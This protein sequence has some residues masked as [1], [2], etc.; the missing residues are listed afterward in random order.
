MGG[1]AN[2]DPD[3]ARATRTENETGKSSV[4]ANRTSFLKDSVEF[5]PFSVEFKGMIPPW[6]VTLQ[7]R[8][9]LMGNGCKAKTAG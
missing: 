5:P 1:Q 6:K 8:L 7:W 9:A 3:E 2:L 4:T